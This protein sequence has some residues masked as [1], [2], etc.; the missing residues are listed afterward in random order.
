MSSVVQSLGNKLFSGSVPIEQMLKKF[1]E[2]GK[3]ATDEI[4]DIITVKEGERSEISKLQSDLA[5]ARTIIAHISDPLE[6]GFINK[7][8]S[9]STQEPGALGNEFFKNV[10]VDT[11]AITGTTTLA[12]KQ[13]ATASDLVIRTGVAST[14]FADTGALGLDG[15]L[16]L[17]AAGQA[18]DTTTVTA[19]T[20]EDVINKINIGFLSNNKEFEAFK[21]AGPTGKAFI[22]GRAKNTGAA[23]SIT[24]AY[25][26][27]TG[28]NATKMAQESIVNGIDSN[29]YVNGINLVQ[30]SNKFINVVPGLS[31]D[32]I[33]A[34]TRPNT[35]IAASYANL[36]HEKIDVHTD[37]SPVQKMVADFG[38][39]LNELSYF[40][41]KN[42]QSSGSIADTKFADP[43][44][45]FGSFNDNNSPLRNSSLLGEVED[46]F[47]Y[48]AVSKPSATGDIQSILD[49]GF[50]IQS[51]RK[52]G[53]K[54]S[55]DRLVFSDKAMFEK[56]FEDDFEGVKNFFV[57]NAKITPTGGNVGYVQY[58]PAE[59]AK[60]VTDPFVI[61]K[62]IEL[63][64]TYDGASAVTKA[65]VKVSGVNVDGIISH[66]ASSGRYNISFVGTTL[67]GIDLSID[68]NGVKNSVE[69]SNINYTPGLVNIV[70]QEIRDLLSDDG[71]SGYTV[72][73]ASNVYDKIE[74]SRKELV[75]V[76]EEFE[77]SKREIEEI[78]NMISFM[79]QQ[80]NLLLAAI[81]AVL[82]D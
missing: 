26:D 5:A 76:E 61:G 12:I 44:T 40:V 29:I 65:V 17:T 63:S 57:T 80:M 36:Y 14:G 78:E 73:E 79:E 31:F 4:K 15:K 32:V 58:I 64:V 60:L 47:S 59:S 16:T 7:T 55:Y 11:T 68:P 66:N 74:A 51:D 6:T 30:A 3:K 54:F 69:K 39:A 48:L 50:S 62:D 23:S 27:N 13:V 72:I 43:S 41:A 21:L 75:A 22:E 81:E 49:L 67:D 77:K 28:V 45:D 70:R 42:S 37:N 25:V 82:I 20:L 56:K 18:I 34:N 2:E 8:S 10:S 19:D 24:C 52:E 33:K 9:V 35:G 1:D 53:D 46:L 38:D 71:L